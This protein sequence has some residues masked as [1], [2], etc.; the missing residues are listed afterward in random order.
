MLMGFGVPHPWACISIST[1]LAESRNNSF[2]FLFRAFVIR[3]LNL[4]K[5]KSARLA[6]ILEVG[7]TNHTKKRARKDFIS[8]AFFRVIRLFRGELHL[9]RKWCRAP[10]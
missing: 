4:R 10:P 7:N 6:K 3:I 1:N 8:K 5:I 9:I 2:E